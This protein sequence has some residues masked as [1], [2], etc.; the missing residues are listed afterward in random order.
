[1]RKWQDLMVTV[2]KAGIILRDFCF[3]PESQRQLRMNR[4]SDKH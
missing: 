3:E 1:M 2:A 4:L